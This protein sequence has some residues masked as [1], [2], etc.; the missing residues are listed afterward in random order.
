MSDNKLENFKINPATVKAENIRPDLSEVS[1]YG[2][3]KASEGLRSGVVNNKAEITGITTDSQQFKMTGT[4]SALG[5]FDEA[6]ISSIQVGNKPF[7]LSKPLAVEVLP[8]GKISGESIKQVETLLKEGK[9]EVAKTVF[10]MEIPFS[11][12]E[13]KLERAN[14]EREAALS[15]SNEKGDMKIAMAQTGK[16]P[17]LAEI[18]KMTGSTQGESLTIPN[19]SGAKAMGIG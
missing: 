11:K 16:D 19:N 13:I 8:D 6:E 3:R 10:G 5:K 2:L 14:P 18:A 4:A 12:E 15:I 7:K 9:V 17:V 1:D